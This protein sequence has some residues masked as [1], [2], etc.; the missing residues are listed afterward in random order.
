MGPEGR[1]LLE[2][3]VV[4]RL[5][6]AG[7]VEDLGDLAQQLLVSLCGSVAHRRRRRHRRRRPRRRLLLRGIQHEAAFRFLFREDLLFVF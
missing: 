2:L 5:R 3:P 6:G 7:L 1:E 4:R